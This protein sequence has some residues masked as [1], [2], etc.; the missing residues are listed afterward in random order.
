M[1]CPKC[2]VVLETKLFIQDTEAEQCPKCKGYWLDKDE[3]SYFLKQKED[4]PSIKKYHSTNYA[5]Y[6][7]PKCKDHPFLTPL[8]YHPAI[9]IIVDVCSKCMG[10]WLDTGEFTFIKNS[11][12]KIDSYR[13]SSTPKIPVVKEKEVKVTDQ[14]ESKT[15]GDQRQDKTEDKLLSHKKP[16]KEETPSTMDADIFWE[17]IRPLIP[18]VAIILL[19]LWIGGRGV[20]VDRSFLARWLF[21]FV[22]ITCTIASLFIYLNQALFLLGAIVGKGRVI[23]VVPGVDSDNNTIYKAC[24]QYIS[25]KGQY[26]EFEDTV[27]R[28]IPLE[29]D[30]EVTVYYNPQEAIVK[31]YFS[32]WLLFTVTSILGLEFGIASLFVWF[33]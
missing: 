30:S 31:N 9:P 5:T 29:V 28:S 13:Q 15:E 19:N 17:L 33:L 4:I 6:K 8:L 3:L 32:V 23:R 14:K 20:S 18:L 16:K 21:P 22:S 11:V 27:S 25:S 1:Q 26:Y 7:C 10:I 24:I 12:S 2:R